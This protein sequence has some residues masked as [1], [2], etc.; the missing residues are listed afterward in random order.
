VCSSDLVEGAERVRDGDLTA[1]VSADSEHDELAALARAFNEMTAQLASQRDELVEATADA[2]KRREFTE[3][4]LSGAS[5]GIVGVD[6]AGKVT[7]VNRSALDLLDVRDADDIVDKPIRDV[8]PELCG[9]LDQ[10]RQASD[11]VADGQVD[12]PRAS[13]IRN[14][15][16]RAAA[17]KDD[18]GSVVLTFDDITRLVTAQRNAAW[19]DV[20]RRIAHEIKNP[21]TPIQLSA[22][23]LRRKYLKDVVGDK[24][25]FERCVDTIIRQVSDIGR[26]VD[27]FSSFARMPEP[28]PA[29]VEMGELVRASAF[30]QRVAS[31]NIEVEFTGPEEPVFVMCD[32]RLIAQAL[33]NVLKNAA[34]SVSTRQDQEP[35]VKN[36][37]GRIGVSVAVEDGFAVVESVDDGLGWPDTPRERL[38]EPYMTTREK[39]TGLGLAIVRRVVED[40]AGRLELADRRDGERGAVV[41]IILPLDVSDAG[42]GTDA[43]EEPSSEQVNV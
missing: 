40:H 35:G 4:V 21:L 29:R 38:S 16:L 31:P 3:A 1:R 15:D 22:E 10:A 43:D 33:T 11:R 34:E 26:M 5:A 18:S 8:A 41:R 13:G 14:L 27:E 20:A 23:R 30:A 9:V 6:A 32:E 42:V 12:L 19:A 24:E 37:S 17:A 25:V 7:L 2:D 36:G 28:K 39:G